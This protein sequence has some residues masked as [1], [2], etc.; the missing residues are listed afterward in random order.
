MAV[1]Q[2]VLW[3]WEELMGGGRLGVNVIKKNTLCET[4]NKLIKKKSFK[5]S[6]ER[7]LGNVTDTFDR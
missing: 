6:F 7:D 5:Y 2:I 1:L 3:C 4:L